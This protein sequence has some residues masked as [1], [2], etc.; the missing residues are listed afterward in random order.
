MRPDKGRAPNRL[1]LIASGW[2]RKV[3]GSWLWAKMTLYLA[4]PLLLQKA[5]RFAR[6][7]AK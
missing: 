5:A 7:A 2:R 3:K 4:K 6:R 1:V